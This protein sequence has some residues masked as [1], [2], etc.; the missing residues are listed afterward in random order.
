MTSHETLTGT[1]GDH[2]ELDHPP[3]DP[4]ALLR[5]WI[6]VAT[7]R[8]VPEPTAASLATIGADGAPSSRFVALKDVTDRGVVFATSAESPKG[9]QMTADPHVALNLYWPTTLQQVRMTGRA[10]ALDDVE[11][12][13]LFHA[14]SVSSQ[15][16]TAASRQ[17]EPLG[18][19]A[20]LVAAV[21]ELERQEQG[22]VRP[23]TWRG[24]LV[25][26]A[27]IEFWV[28][29]RDRL[30]RRLHYTH[31]DETWTATRLQP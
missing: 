17:S 20:D 8:G 2:P 29:S 31:L 5:T 25:T 27:E 26:V 18:S 15:A 7:D 23:A 21:R 3:A 19:E 22:V 9:R 10:T 4:L 24:W 11:S 13:R 14:R 6:E 1:T 30:H 16:A 12:D 28:G